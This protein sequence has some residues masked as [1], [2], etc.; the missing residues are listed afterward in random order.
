MQSDVKNWHGTTIIGVLKNGAV[1]IAGDA[2]Y[3]SNNNKEPKKSGG[4]PWYLE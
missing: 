2:S 3:S 4:E 1:S